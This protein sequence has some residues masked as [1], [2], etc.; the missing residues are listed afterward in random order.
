MYECVF[1]LIEGNVKR[2]FRKRGR[3]KRRR[4]RGRE[5]EEGREGKGNAVLVVV[6]VN[7]PCLSFRP[8]LFVFKPYVTNL[9]VRATPLKHRLPHP[10]LPPSRRPQDESITLT[11]GDK[12][13]IS[14]FSFPRGHRGRHT[15]EKNRTLTFFFCA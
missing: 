12:S 9:P 6:W 10:P 2:R 14:V 13:I 7:G 15:R 4:T 11:D 5:S 1:V 3:R 8:I